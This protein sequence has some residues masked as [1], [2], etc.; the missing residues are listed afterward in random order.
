MRYRLAL[1]LLVT[2]LVTSAVS[3]AAE[4]KGPKSFGTYKNYGQSRSS[5]QKTV[6]MTHPTGA[7]RSSSEHAI[8]MSGGKK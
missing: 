8:N 6:N 7:V 2:T 1:A 3:Q 5:A 4:A